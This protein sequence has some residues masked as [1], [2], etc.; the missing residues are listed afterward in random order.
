[1]PVQSF[2]LVATPSEVIDDWLPACA[3]ELLGLDGL[4]Q[5]DI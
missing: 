3:T 4:D 5:G 2:D 1:M